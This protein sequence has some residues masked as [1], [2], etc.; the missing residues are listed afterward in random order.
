M[1]DWDDKMQTECA[2]VFLKDEVVRL[3][4]FAN[5]QKLMEGCLSIILNANIENEDVLKTLLIEIVYKQLG[6]G[7]QDFSAVSAS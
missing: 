7:V 3:M 1:N 2:L 4:N 6:E 5:Q